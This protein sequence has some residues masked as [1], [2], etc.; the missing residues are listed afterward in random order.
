MKD[1]LKTA[2]YIF[3]LFLSA[4]T[5]KAQ[6]TDGREMRGVWIATVKNLD[7]P[8]SGFLST[9]EQKKE[10]IDLLNYYSKTGI[11]AVFFQVRPAADAFFPSEYEPWSEW[12]TGK[13]G[14]APYPYY[15]PL[16][17]MIKECHKRNIQFHAWINP[18]RAV[19]T[20]E[21]ADIAENH[22]TNRKPEWFFTYGINKYFDPGIPEVRKYVTNII[23]DIVERYDIDGVHFDDYFYPYPIRDEHG[24]IV[25]I[26]DNKTFNTYNGGFD[27]IEDWRRN[28]MDIFIKD[29]FDAVKTTKPYVAFGVSPSGV[30]RNKSKDPEGSNTRG[31]AHYD[32]LY[33]DVLKWLKNGWIDYVAP[34]LYWPVGNKYADYITLVNW[35][36]KHTY[37]K[38]LY[39][40]QAVYNVNKDSKD[41]SWR[42][43]N[44]LPKQIRINRNNPEVLGSIF[45]RS[46]SMLA[47]P[48]GFCD[49]LQYHYYRKKVL[50]PLI[51]PATIID[52]NIIAV[53]V[54][55]N[56]NNDLKHRS[57]IKAPEDIFITKLGKNIMISW[58]KNK[59][60]KDVSYTIYKFRG[61]SFKYA[62]EKDIYAT[63]DK[64]YILFQRKRLPFL[65]KEYTV[66]I[67]PE[68]SSGKE[69]TD[70]KT[71]Y[72]KL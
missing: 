63:T 60:E 68:K 24:K 7:Y 10:F 33:S 61:Y 23:K 56:N 12:L 58:D 62:D 29:V 40:G 31:L 19:A 21:Y 69:I 3:I 6:A 55:E 66:V 14:K 49:S 71:V 52:T 39:I 16:K 34:Q 17:F 37:G 2:F 4:Q 51:P 25:P 1:F 46:K 70:I 65:R 15:D 5:G 44:E 45:Y 9:A 53:T 54:K 41:P 18:F 8:S 48:L 67:T 27:N 20:I 38:Q 26:P 35:W 72:L 36:S 59:I 13:Q 30:W 43:P 47:N 57:E 64:P 22:I 11:N 50:P 42:N 28:N 32:Y